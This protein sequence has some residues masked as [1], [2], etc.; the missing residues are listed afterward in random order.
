MSPAC[1][2]SDPADELAEDNPEHQRGVVGFGAFA[3]IRAEQRLEVEECDG[4]VNES[5]EVI[6]GE[7]LIDVDPLG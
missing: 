5:G 4:L 3:G 7:S 2:R 1:G 6:V